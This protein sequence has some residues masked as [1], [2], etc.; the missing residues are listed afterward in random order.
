MQHLLLSPIV[1]FLLAA[2]GPQ[3]LA[4]EDPRPEPP[5]MVTD[6]PDAT[7]SASVVPGGYF[8]V[9]MGWSHAVF[10][11]QGNETTIATLDEGNMFGEMALFDKGIRSASVKTI[12]PC[13]VLIF[14]GNKFLELLLG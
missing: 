11:E 8:Q 7:E 14:E 9:E 10:E 12:E 2:V 3:L 1:A 4:A 6:R 13:R 5:E